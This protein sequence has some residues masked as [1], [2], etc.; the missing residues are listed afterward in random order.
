LE[1]TIGS[2]TSLSIIRNQLAVLGTKSV[3]IPLVNCLYWH[4]GFLPI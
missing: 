2:S 4:D 3:W 1:S